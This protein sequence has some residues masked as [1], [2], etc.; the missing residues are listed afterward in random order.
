[1]FELEIYQWVVPL[2]AIIYA[3]RV[4]KQYRANKRLFTSTFFWIVFWI[5]VTMLAL[6]PHEISIRIAK[7]MGIKDNVNAVI[8]VALGF[9][10]SIIF[11][12]SAT[13]E[14]LEKQITDLIRKIALE[15]SDMDIEETLKK[16]KKEVEQ[17][18]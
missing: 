8:F 11:Y 15:S 3:I 10:F 13:V 16:I 5:A 7:V 9:M 4:V 18:N 2:V 6:V 1:M 12:L 14:K 17:E